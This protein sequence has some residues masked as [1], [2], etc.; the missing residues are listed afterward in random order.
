MI[1]LKGTRVVVVDD[2]ASDALPVLKAFAQKGVPCAFFDGS[3]EGLPEENEQLSGVRL[4][5]LDMDLVGVGVS[6]KS[7][8]AT[9]QAA[10]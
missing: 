8:A 3:L 4:A 2:E 6:D 5:I 10:D 1:G 7:K 9:L